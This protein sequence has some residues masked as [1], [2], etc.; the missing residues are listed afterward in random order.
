MIKWRFKMRVMPATCPVCRVGY[1]NLTGCGVHLLCRRCGRHSGHLGNR[2]ARRAYRAGHVC[3]RTN[4][5]ANGPL[6]WADLERNP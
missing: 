2:T 1:L 6:G 3:E 5:W 4:P